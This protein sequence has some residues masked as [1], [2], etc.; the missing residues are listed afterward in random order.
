MLAFLVN[1]DRG[2]MR[3]F[4]GSAPV[5]EAD[6]IGC[7]VV[8]LRGQPDDLVEH[9]LFIQMLLEMSAAAQI[10][11]ELLGGH[12]A[13]PHVVEGRAVVTIF[14]LRP[15][16]TISLLWSVKVGQILG[17]RRGTHDEHRWCQ[18]RPSRAAR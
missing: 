15:V 14:P 7:L 11:L 10:V 18:I 2:L 17:S 13:K 8:R 3:Q 16:V 6:E 9:A 12:I 5:R 1:S 4:P